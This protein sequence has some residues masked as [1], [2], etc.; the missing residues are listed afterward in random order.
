MQIGSSATLDWT[1]SLTQDETLKASR[2]SLI[3][4]E[5]ERFLYSNQW[6]IMVVKQFSG[7]FHQAIGG[8]D[9]FDVIP[10]ND[11]TLRL[12]N[13]TDTDLTRFRCTFLS[14]F[15]APNSIIQME[16][17]G[18]LSFFRTNVFPVFPDSYLKTVPPITTNT[19]LVYIMDCSLAALTITV[20]SLY[21]GHPRNRELV[22]VI[23]RF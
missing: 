15:A 3:L 20:N 7:G 17:K 23:A 13:V 18:E 9:T 5:R 1:V 12:N 11:M 19:S 16:I 21:R 6:Q 2:F 10:G 4:L 14:S 8:Q 22:S